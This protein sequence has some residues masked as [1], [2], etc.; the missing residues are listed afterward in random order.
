[1]LLRTLENTLHDFR[2]TAARNLIR[3]GVAEK[4]AMAVTGH[5]TR[6][7]FDR[8][9]IVGEFSRHDFKAGQRRRHWKALLLGLSMELRR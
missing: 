4:M 9:N 5:K 8:Y 7:V 1:V 2:R 3:A 6:S